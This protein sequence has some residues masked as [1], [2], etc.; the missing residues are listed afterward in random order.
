MLI[1]IEPEAEDSDNVVE[2]SEPI[3]SP[4]KKGILVNDFTS[5]RLSTLWTFT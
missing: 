3:A 5:L 2:R 4:M 1:D